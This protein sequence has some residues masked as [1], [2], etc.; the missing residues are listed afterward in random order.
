LGLGKVR[1]RN[2][3]G[4]RV[5]KLWKVRESGSEVIWAKGINESALKKNVKKP[6]TVGPT[7]R[8]N[9]RKCLFCDS[10]EIGVAE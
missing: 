4:F 6:A 8:R 9:H 7:S 2:K 1:M 5:L 3:I 10:S